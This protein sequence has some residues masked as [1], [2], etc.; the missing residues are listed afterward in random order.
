MENN[1]K[2]AN[3]PNVQVSPAM[4]GRHLANLFVGDVVNGLAV[5]PGSGLAVIVK[6]GNALIPFKTGEV[7]NARLVSLVADYSLVSDAADPSNPRID[8]VVLYVD[9]SVNLPEITP[10]N[11]P[12]SGHTDGPAIAKIK[13]VKGAPNANPQIPNASA[14]Q[15]SIGGGNPYTVLARRLVRAGSNTTTEADITDMRH[16]AKLGTQNINFTTLDTGDVEIPIADTSGSGFT[17]YNSSIPILARRVGKVVQVRGAVSPKHASNSIKSTIALLPKGMQP[18]TTFTSLQ[19]GSGTATWN[20]YV[21]TGG[22]L[23]LD[24]YNGSMSTSSW[25]TF[26]VTF[27]AE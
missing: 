16:W 18:S 9:N 21:E 1:V 26:S 13:I 14:I 4:F 17:L 20:M 22:S 27:L 10:T 24:R 2:L 6:P 7:Y 11:P 25:L 3:Y 12:T 19:Q 23:R 8:L 15:A 5:E